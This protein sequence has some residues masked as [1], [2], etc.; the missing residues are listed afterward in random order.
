MANNETGKLPEMTPEEF[1]AFWKKNLKFIVISGL[2]GAGKTEL[3][4]A[5]AELLGYKVLLEP[6][7]D[8][9]YLEQFYQHPE[10]WAYPMQEFLKHRRFAAYH[11]GWWGI[12]Y[13]EFQGIIMDRSI[14]EDTVFAEIN[15]DLGTIADLN[16]KTYLQGFQDFQTFL[17]EPDV[18]I[19]LDAKPETC[20]QRVLSRGRAAE[21][22][23]G[24]DKEVKGIPLD[25]MVRLKEGYEKWIKAVSPRLPFVRIDWEK[26]R[27][28]DS[29][30][31]EVVTRVEERSRFTRSLTA[32]KVE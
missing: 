31:H 32:P 7:E 17:P 3:S 5:L 16:W 25:Y 10:T 12:R 23:T 18:I 21:Q 11:F 26:F 27:S 1:V 24:F 29:L 22:K 30:W 14:H 6:V 8:N 13:G 4:K 15:H 20:C 9:P 2:I 28:T 19:Y